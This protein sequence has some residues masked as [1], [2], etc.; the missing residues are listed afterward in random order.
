[1]KMIELQLQLN[2]LRILT[3]IWDMT[4]RRRISSF[5]RGS[6]DDRCKKSIFVIHDAGTITIFKRKIIKDI[7]II[8]KSITVLDEFWRLT[9]RMIRHFLN[10]KDSGCDDVQTVMTFC[11]R[12]IIAITNYNKERGTC[13]DTLSISIMI[14]SVWREKTERRHRRQS[15]SREYYTSGTDLSDGS[16]RKV[17]IVEVPDTKTNSCVSE[18]VRRTKSSRSMCGSSDDELNW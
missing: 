18:K 16:Q 14:R 17:S 1:M 6:W 4:T 12:N 5:K 13:V 7:G 8:Q 11:I 2:L 3:F 9:T 15:D 10:T